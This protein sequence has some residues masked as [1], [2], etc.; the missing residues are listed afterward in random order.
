MRSVITP[1][2]LRA[3]GLYVNGGRKRGWRKRLSVLLDTPESTIASW[4]TRSPGNTRSI[5]GST[6]VA[7]KLLVGMVRQ[8]EL[9]DGSLPS[10]V[11]TVTEQV[12]TLLSA[13]DCLPTVTE[14]PSKSVKP[15]TRR[16]VTARQ[17]NDRRSASLA[18][19]L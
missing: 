10:A 14:L 6:V 4:A 16:S 8:R 13:P 11:D 7:L 12:L 17:K 18:Q 9:A 5:P 1:E 3:A 19:S 15:R 2:Q